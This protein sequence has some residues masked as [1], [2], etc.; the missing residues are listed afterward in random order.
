MVRPS[1]MSRLRMDV[2]DAASGAT[3]LECD[4]RFA[5][6]EG[7]NP[8]FARQFRSG[9]PQAGNSSQSA[10]CRVRQRDLTDRRRLELNVSK[11]VGAI[12]DVLL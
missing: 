5:L 10:L 8:R 2:F 6:V 9:G 12:E 11:S 7:E 3:I 4:V 1:R